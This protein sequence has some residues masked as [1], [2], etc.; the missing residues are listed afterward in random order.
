[1]A[2]ETFNYSAI[3]RAKATTKRNIYNKVPIVGKHFNR[4]GLPPKVSGIRWISPAIY[5]KKY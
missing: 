5:Y 3:D 1:M 2:S 4:I